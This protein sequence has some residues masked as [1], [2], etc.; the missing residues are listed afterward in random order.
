MA[1]NRRNVAKER[2][3]NVEGKLDNLTR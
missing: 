1:K 2:E 3:N